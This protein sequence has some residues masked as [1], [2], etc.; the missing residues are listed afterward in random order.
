VYNTGFCWGNLRERD[1]LE[2]P[3][4]Y[5][6]I[7]LRWVFRKWY[8]DAWMGFIWLSIGTVAGICECGN[9]PSGSIKCQ[10]FDY[11]RPS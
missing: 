3:G 4:I 8:G 10:E 7:I 11:L 5:G 9:E 6:R 1:H 2:E